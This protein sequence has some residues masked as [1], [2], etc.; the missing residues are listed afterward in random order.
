ME[1]C[2]ACAQ[3]MGTLKAAEDQGVQL[4]EAGIHRRLTLVPAPAG[5]GKTTL[6]GGGATGASTRQPG[7][8]SKTATTILSAFCPTS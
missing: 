2:K 5:F 8:P 4:L 6:I 3:K 1:V 7:C